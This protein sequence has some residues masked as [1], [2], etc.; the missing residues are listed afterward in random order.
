MSEV[1]AQIERVTREFKRGG[2]VVRA[3]DGIDLAVQRGEFV[4]IMGKSGSGKSTLLHLMSGLQRPTRGRVVLLG[5]DL[6]SLSDDAL[7]LL[8]RQHVGFVFQFF[9]LLPTLSAL[10]NVALPLLLSSV[11][12]SE[13][14]G[15]ARQVLETVGL[16]ERADHKPD[17]LSG[18]QMQR[19]AIARALV[20][21]PALLF[22]DEPTG[23]LDSVSS[24]EILTLLKTTQVEQGQTIIMVT[25]DAK[26]AAYGDRVITLRDG[27]VHED[28]ATRSVAV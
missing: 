6:G 1:I 14:A 2:S 26:A 28:L 27:R 11:R 8:R 5:H 9:N 20:N 18:G 7:T 10:E 17:E 13:A 4:A 19:V 23:N 15:R 12:A 24:E 16:Q 21:R 3:V 25:H 22:A